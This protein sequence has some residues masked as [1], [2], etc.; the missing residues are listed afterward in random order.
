MCNITVTDMNT[1]HK[2]KRIMHLSALASSKKQNSLCF[3]LCMHA[4]Q[5]ETMSFKYCSI[6]YHRV[7]YYIFIYV[8]N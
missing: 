2:K 7:V 1:P 8:Y 6:L 4:E 3:K 5:L